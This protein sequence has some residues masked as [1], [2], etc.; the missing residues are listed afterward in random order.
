MKFNHVNIDLK[1]ITLDVF[2]M[3]FSKFSPTFKYIRGK[4][5]KKEITVGI[6]CDGFQFLKSITIY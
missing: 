4:K 3:R 1:L 5:K 2:V 6:A